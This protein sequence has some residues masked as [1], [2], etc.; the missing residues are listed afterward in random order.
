M[1]RSQT[2]N[3]SYP[4]PST[5]SSH[6]T[7]S[8]SSVSGDA[9]KAPQRDRIET[10]EGCT[11]CE[12][13][14]GVQRAAKVYEDEHVMAFLDIL[15][16]R[17]G[18]LLVVPKAHYARVSQL[19]SLLSSHLGSVLPLLS[20]SLAKALKNPDFNIVSNTGY[21]QI[22]HHVHFHIV[23]APNLNSSSNTSTSTNPNRSGW[24]SLVG[25]EELD[26]SEGE[27]LARRIRECVHEQLAREK[28]ARGKGKGSSKL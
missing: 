4:Q 21:A 25:R 11:F 7:S 16:I 5:S 13:R 6:R 3:S 2:A 15:P 9:D 12:I 24:A 14:D 8:A 10:E 1:A 19:P 26:E 22:V 27:E 28:E 17:E 18:H 23:P 20:R